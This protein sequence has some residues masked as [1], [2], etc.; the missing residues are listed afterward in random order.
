MLTAIGALGLPERADAPRFTQ[1][2]QWGRRIDNLATSEA[3]R[4]L[5]AFAQ[6]EGIP[7]IFYERKYGPYSR[8]YGYAKALMMV[9]DTHVV[10]TIVIFYVCPNIVKI[11]CP[12]SMTDGAA[13]V[14]ELI[15]TPAMKRDLFPRLIRYTSVSSF[16]PLCKILF[17]LVAIHQWPLHRANG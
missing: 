11:F 1:Y 14:I 7:A 12:L 3:W 15:G 10:R 9:G 13:R 6:K 8:L 16:G 17:F 4:S 2:D 5:K